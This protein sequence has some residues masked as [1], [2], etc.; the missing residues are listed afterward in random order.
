[1]KKQKTR[2]D[3]RTGYK[4]WSKTYDTDWNPLIK[5]EERS[6]LNSIGN[7]RNKTVLDAGCGTGRVVLKILKKGAKVYGIDISNEMLEI[8]KRKTTKYKDKREFKLASVY[9]IPYG[10]NEFDLVVCNL[11]TSHLKNLNKAL[12]EMAR[13]LKPRGFLIISD[14]HP[15]AMKLGAGTV[16]F[17]NKKEYWI[18]NYYHTLEE[19]FNVLKKNKLKI[20]EIKEPKITK[21]IVPKEEYQ[22]IGKP[23]ALIIKA[24]K[25]Q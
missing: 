4:I 13:V 3:I 21:R 12:S 17:Q 25:V 18:R 11:V 8:A 5:L 15:F 23:G 6:L 24:G 22:W 1:M 2:L 9:D 19:V 7:I 14:L 16:F 20:S 10:K